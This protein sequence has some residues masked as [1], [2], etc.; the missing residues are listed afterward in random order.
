MDGALQ[1]S[2]HYI[3]SGCIRG[4]IANPHFSFH[5]PFVFLIRSNVD[6]LW[7]RWQNAPGHAWRLGPE[8]VHGVHDDSP[9]STVNAVLQPLAGGAD[10]NVRP[11]STGEDPSDPPTAKTSKDPTVVAPAHDDR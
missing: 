6:R 8:H 11:W 1:G 9:A 7:D 5:D 10:G 2:H 4:T 3:H